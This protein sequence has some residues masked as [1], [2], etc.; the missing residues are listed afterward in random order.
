M[1]KA[2]GLCIVVIILAF[3]VIKC[4]STVPYKIVDGNLVIH[5][6]VTSIGDNAFYGNQHKQ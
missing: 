5:N 1:K 3:L 6:G 2:F 4:T